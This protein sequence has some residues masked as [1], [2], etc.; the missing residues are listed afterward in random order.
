WAAGQNLNTA[1]ASVGYTDGAGNSTSANDSDDAN[2]F[3]AEPSLT[4]VKIGILHN[5][6]VTPNSRTDAGD[7]VDYSFTVTNTGNVTLTG[8]TVTDSFTATNCLIGTLTP[9]AMDS[10]T[11]SASHTLTQPE[12]DSGSVSN[13][14]LA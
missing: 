13:T 1:S 10:T 7:R 9:G 12:V 6:V 5:D 14:A 11:C 2:Y 4:I 8:V 3:G